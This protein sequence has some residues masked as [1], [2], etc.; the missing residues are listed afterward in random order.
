MDIVAGLVS[1]D[2]PYRQARALCT[3]SDGLAELN[4]QDIPRYS[5]AKGYATPTLGRLFKAL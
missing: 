1:A 2:L 4:P 5:V 3:G